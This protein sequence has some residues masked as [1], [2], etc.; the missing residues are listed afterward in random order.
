[1]KPLNDK[2]RDLLANGL[3]EIANIIIG[4][5]IVGQ[6]LT[7]PSINWI[8]LG[9]GFFLSTLLYLLAIY[10]LRKKRGK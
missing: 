3:K 6:I 8:I 9:G 10:I 1:M 7:F 4:A 2:Q 5:S